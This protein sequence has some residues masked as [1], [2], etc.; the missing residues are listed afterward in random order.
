M[1]VESSAKK[2]VESSGMIVE[3]SAKKI[4]VHGPQVKLSARYNGFYYF[5]NA[6]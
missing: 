3:S 6:T 1:I 2:I 4:V 5:I